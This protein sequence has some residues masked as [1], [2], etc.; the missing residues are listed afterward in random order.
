MNIGDRVQIP[1]YTDRWMM[2]DRYG[3]VDRF[4]KAA[5]GREMAWVLMD[6]SEK[7][8]RFEVAELEPIQ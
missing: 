2:G 7:V 5:N 6:K 3:S 1:V 4:Y 8:C